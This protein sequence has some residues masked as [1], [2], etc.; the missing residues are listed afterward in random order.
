MFHP[1]KSAAKYTHAAFLQDPTIGTPVFVRFSTVAG[2]AGLA[3]LP[4]DVHRFATKFYTSDGIFDL[5]GNNIPVFFTNQHASTPDTF[6]DFISLAPESLHRVMWVMSD[7]AI[8]RSY[9]MMEGFGVHTFRMID[10][11]GHATFIKWH[12][13]PML[14]TQSVR[15]N[16]AVKI[17]QADQDFHHRDLFTSIQNIRFPAWELSIPPIAED[18]V[19]DLD[20]D[21]FDPT[22]LI[23]EEQIPLVPIGKMVLD[24]WQNH[25]FAETEHTAFYPGQIVP[26]IELVNDPRLQ[27]RVS[28]YAH[29]AAERLGATHHDQPELRHTEH[30]LHDLPRKGLAP[31]PIDEDRAHHRTDRSD[32][33]S[34]ARMFWRSMIPPEQRHIASAFTFELSKVEAPAIRRRMLGHLHLIAPELGGLVAGALGMMETAP[35]RSR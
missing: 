35:H 6:W 17:D 13:R 2:G 26:G 1:Y 5:V 11:K 3:D 8:P 23:R 33:Y 31:V 20:V 34:Q 4:R 30:S 15:W 27:R 22:K 28:S 19:H 29:T 16:E 24:R 7:R 25:F 32:H 21:I 12:W 14:G 9:R 10:A 18:E